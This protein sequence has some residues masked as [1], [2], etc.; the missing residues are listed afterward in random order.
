MPFARLVRAFLR[1]RWTT[2]AYK[3]PAQEEISAPLIDLQISGADNSPIA[4]KRSDRVS[5]SAVT[6]EF[7]KKRAHEQGEHGWAFVGP[8]CD[9]RVAAETLPVG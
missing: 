8:Q 5:G 2:Y 1:L 9:G 6:T 4:A 3:Y 7:L